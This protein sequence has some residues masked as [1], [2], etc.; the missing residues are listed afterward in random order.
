MN[1]L[2]AAALA[3]APDGGPPLTIDPELL[4]RIT[5]ATVLG[6]IRLLD[7]RLLLRCEDAELGRFLE[8][9]VAAFPS[10]EA[11]R[12]RLDVVSVRGYWAAYEDGA[13]TVSAPSTTA[14]ARSLVWQLNRLALA[15]PTQDVLVHAAVASLGARAV[16]MPGRSGAGKTTL[17]T[18]LVLAGWRYLSDEVA[19]LGPGGA[20]VRPYPRPLALEAGSW[21]LVPEAADRWPAGVPAMVSDLRLVLPASLGIP[22]EPTAATPAAIVFPEVVAGATAR[23]EPVARAEALERLLPLTFNLNALGQAGFERLEGCVRRATCHRL[24]LDGLAGVPA[25]VATL[26][27]TGGFDRLCR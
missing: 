4:D 16:V 7:E 20:E 25:L 18:A 11:A 13:R 22:C 5:W 17:V 6:P 24:V 1:V 15:A 19:A 2:D 9:F 8:A 3:P 14:M 10:A 21:S 23:L 27:E 26:V 12:T